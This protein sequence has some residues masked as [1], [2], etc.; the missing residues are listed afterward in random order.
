MRI[1]DRRVAFSDD[2]PSFEPGLAR[3]VQFADDIGKE[4]DPVRLDMH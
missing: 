3:G 2:Q 1:L 4:A